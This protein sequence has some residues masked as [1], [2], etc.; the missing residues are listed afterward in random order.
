MDFITELCLRVHFLSN[1]SA[2]CTILIPTV[3]SPPASLMAQ[4]LIA[5]VG[6]LPRVGDDKDEQRHR[7]ARAHFERKEISA[8]AFRDVEQSITQELVQRQLTYGLDEIT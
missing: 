7:R 1:Q 3:K 8:H 6:S 2:S 5:N 4:L